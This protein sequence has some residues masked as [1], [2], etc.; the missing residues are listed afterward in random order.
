MHECLEI[1]LSCSELIQASDSDDYD[2]FGRISGTLYHAL[3][4]DFDSDSLCAG[5]S[6]S[7]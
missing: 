2:E 1:P 4:S 7:A 5:S 6:L 3:I